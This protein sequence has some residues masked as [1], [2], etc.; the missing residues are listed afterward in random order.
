MGESFYYIQPCY[1][2]QEP[3]EHTGEVEELVGVAL[4][5][6]ATFWGVYKRHS[7][8]TSVHIED[9]DTMDQALD[10]ALSPRDVNVRQ[11]F[12]DCLRSVLIR[13]PTYT[14]SAEVYM[15]RYEFH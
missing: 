8:G 3:D 1:L 7:D 9:H 13:V 14:G 2:Y 4:P 10:A 15:V 6:D 5:K 12:N 11:G